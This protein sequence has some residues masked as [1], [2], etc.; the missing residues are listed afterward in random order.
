MS[1]LL[2]TKIANFGICFKFTRLA[3]YVSRDYTRDSGAPTP[4]RKF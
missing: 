2:I 4:T 3:L 1:I